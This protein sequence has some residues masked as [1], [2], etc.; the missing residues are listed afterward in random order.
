MLMV[1]FMFPLK[2]VFFP[3]VEITTHEKVLLL[4]TKTSKM[5]GNL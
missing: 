5:Y 4:K 2:V 3:Y 1:S